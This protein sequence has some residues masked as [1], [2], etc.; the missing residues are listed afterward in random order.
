M[1]YNGVEVDPEALKKAGDAVNLPAEVIKTAL[2]T[3]YARIGAWPQKPWG[4]DQIGEMFA[5]T[6]EGHNDASPD[7]KGR[8]GHY[9]L[10]G[11]L[12]D[13]I[14]GLENVGGKVKTM[15]VTYQNNEYYN[16]R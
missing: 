2:A 16:S 4:D 13:L 1:I 8:T 15:A 3:F 11:A 10:L 9:K 6:Y 14:S 5:M 7:K 12:E